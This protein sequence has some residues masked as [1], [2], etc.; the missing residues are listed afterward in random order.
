LKLLGGQFDFVH[1]QVVRKAERIDRLASFANG[2]SRRHCYMED[3]KDII[4]FN[5]AKFLANF[6]NLIN[7]SIEEKQNYVD[8]CA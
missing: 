8:T 2:R 1:I 7:L 6:N 3:P 4:Y 5:Q